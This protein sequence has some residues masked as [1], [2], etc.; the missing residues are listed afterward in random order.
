MNMGA[1]SLTREHLNEAINEF[2]DKIME[3][4]GVTVTD[5]EAGELEL[6]G[7]CFKVIGLDGE[8][9]VKDATE[10]SPGTLIVED[11][12]EYF[13]CYMGSD[14]NDPWVRYTGKTYSHA[15]FAEEMREARTIPRIV[16]EG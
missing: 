2:A 15:E 11:V 8:E 9:C 1:T 12:Y 6:S 13:R 10:I 7:T 4:L 14:V 3:A 5:E 16:H